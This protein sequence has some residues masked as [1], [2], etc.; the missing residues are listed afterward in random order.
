MLASIAVNSLIPIQN[1]LV[2]QRCAQ[3]VGTL[4]DGLAARIEADID[5]GLTLDRI[6]ALHA[7]AS[8]QGAIKASNTRSVVASRPIETQIYSTSI[9][10]A[11]R[12]FPLRIGESSGRRPL[13]ASRR[14]MPPYATNSVSAR[15]RTSGR[16]PSGSGRAA[17]VASRSKLG[18][19]RLLVFCSADLG[20][21]RPPNSQQLREAT[22]D[23]KT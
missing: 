2:P 11:V 14:K 7:S 15:Y 1:T 5:A 13:E 6:S 10:C 16:F 9:I 18:G 20:A 21:V 8:G 19:H 3:I 4:I 17:T 12:T 22:F 23:A